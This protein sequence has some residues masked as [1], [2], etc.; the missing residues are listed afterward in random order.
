MPPPPFPSVQYKAGDRPTIVGVI[1]RSVLLVQL[2]AAGVRPS[3]GNL[4]RTCPSISGDNQVE[5]QQTP[6][7]FAILRTEPPLCLEPE[8]EQ[9]EESKEGTTGL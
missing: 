2:V 5:C 4:P 6:V 3:W 9:D 7:L 1:A 8:S